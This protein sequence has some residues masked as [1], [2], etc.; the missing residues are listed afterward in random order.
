MAHVPARAAL[1][2]PVMYL[3]QA[4][5]RFVGG[6]ERVVIAPRLELGGRPVPWV[7]GLGASCVIA[8]PWS[9]LHRLHRRKRGFTALVGR[10][11][12]LVEI[13]SA[14]LASGEPRLEVWCDGEEAPDQLLL[15]K[16]GKQL[17]LSIH[18]ISRAELSDALERVRDAVTPEHLDDEN[19]LVA[20]L[21]FEKSLSQPTE[22]GQETTTSDP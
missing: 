2:Q 14:Q 6:C 10:L 22:M 12:A 19:P 1:D 13:A 17:E 21:A 7:L 20:V 9:H 4:H 5:T 15:E 18:T 16:V 11:R 8:E 3:A